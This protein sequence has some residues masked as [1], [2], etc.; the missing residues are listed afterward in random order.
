MGKKSSE[1]RIGIARE[2]SS[3]DVDVHLGNE[4]NKV[5]ERWQMVEFDRLP[6]GDWMELAYR[7]DFFSL[8]IFITT[9]AVLLLRNMLLL[10][11]ETVGWPLG[12]VSGDFSS[13]NNVTVP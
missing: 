4:I 9:V 3:I 8:F 1:I 11:I 13:I 10:I 7:L 5:G 12:R 2:C 6:N